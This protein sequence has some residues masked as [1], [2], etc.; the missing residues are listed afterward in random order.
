[1]I[2]KIRETILG[3]IRAYKKDIPVI[4]FAIIML[5]M[6]R[7]WQDSVFGYAFF[8]V[9][10]FWMF[11][12]P[13]EQKL[14][15]LI[16]LIPWAES[17]QMPGQMFGIVGLNPINVLFLMIVGTVIFEKRKLTS[18]SRF[19]C[20]IGIFVSLLFISMFRGIANVSFQHITFSYYFLN[21]FLKP[22]QIILSGI[23]VFYIL[24]EPKQVFHFLRA[25]K[26]SGALLGVWVLLR[27][28]HSVET[29]WA[30]TRTLSI[31]KNAISF[32]FLTLLS[33][34]LATM[35]YGD[36]AE[37][38]ANRVLSIIYI[39]VVMFTFSRQGY[40]S[41]VLVLFFFSVQKGF[42]R[43]MLFII[44]LVL[45]WSFFMPFSVKQRIYTGTETG[46][47]MGVKAHLTGDVSA[48]RNETWAASMP[49][50]WEHP[51][52]GQGRLAYAKSVRAGRE[53]L[54]SHPHNAY[55]QCM[56]DNGMVGL[57]IIVGFYVFLMMK[58][59]F[60][61]KR[62]KSKFARAYGF[63]FALTMG[64]FLLQGYTGFRFYPYEESYF[65][66]FYLGGL[67]WVYENQ[68]YLVEH[69]M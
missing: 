59:W 50:V 63:G 31:H 42:K 61:Y 39:L 47:K 52:F 21:I 6:G 54:P 43:V 67:M 66:W 30:M 27:S 22:L 64:V 15:T 26:L 8:P 28:G 9:M 69:G 60:L 58:S 40:V 46:E 16:F 5:K 20:A 38:F 17:R 11:R 62:S 49:V 37:K 35:D 25:I 32:I 41:C 68:G 55:I 10:F 29:I 3:V 33:M 56:L 4:L 34:N 12:M 44:G 14:H 23:M 48:G 24:R 13:L 36:K 7:R 53:Y 51:L 57:I 18:R 65:V 45:F 19:N 1:M 2:H